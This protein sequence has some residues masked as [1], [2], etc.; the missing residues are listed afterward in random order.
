MFSKKDID[1]YTSK[2]ISPEILEHQLEKFKTGFPF[3]KIVRSASPGDGLLIFSDTAKKTLINGFDQLS[4][5]LSLTK[6]VPASGAAT[7]MFK[8]LFSIL[9]KLSGLPSSEQ[10]TIVSGDSEISTFFSELKSYPFFED[11][12]LDGGET[13]EQ[14]LRKLLDENG[15]SYGTLPKG[16][17]KFHSYDS[18]GRTAFEEHLREAAGYCA[19]GGS[20]N[21]HFTISPEHKES[22]IALQ[23]EIVPALEKEYSL[24]FYLI[25]SF[26]KE[27]TDTIAV[28]NDNQPFRDAEGKLV[29]RPGGHGALLEN[30]NEIS[31]DIIFISNIDNVAPDKFKPE[32]VDNKKYLGAILLKVRE[33][34]YTYL[35]IL[36]AK[37]IPGKEFF[38]ELFS[39]MTNVMY[40]SVPEGMESGESAD[41]KAWAIDIL[42]R[43]VRVCGMVKNEGEAGGG[44]FFVEDGEGHISLQVVEPSQIDVNNPAQKELLQSSTHFNPVDL[45]CSTR[46]HKGEKYNLMKYRDPDTGFITAKSMLGKDLKAQELPGLWNGSMAHWTTI[47]VEVPMSTFTPVKTVFD[48]TRPEHQG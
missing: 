15:L 14:I 21:M 48:L 42:D 41:Q 31:A 24:I 26:Q 9:E 17:L 47:F 23:N 16:L 5:G 4:E 29:F 34:I 33:E 11:L 38:D 6:F 12:Q 45:V 40:I 35:A 13:P 22:F 10:E 37:E 18:G 43:P 30:L 36:K 2:G 7:R 32:R 1:Q 19:Q 3:S 39:W 46:N 28:D 44:P 25:Y 20:V 27:E 8:S